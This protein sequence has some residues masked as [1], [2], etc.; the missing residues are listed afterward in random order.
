MDLPAW[1]GSLEIG[2]DWALWCGSVGESRLHSH[3]AAQAAWSSHGVGIVDAAGLQRQAPCVLVE[4]M[5]PHRLLAGESVTLIFVEPRRNGLVRLPPALQAS[6]CAALQGPYAIIPADPDAFFWPSPLV[7]CAEVDCEWEQ[8]VRD[9]V[10]ADLHKGRLE[11]AWVAGR[12]N[13]STD[14]FRHVFAERLGMPFKRFV[15]WRRLR[16]AVTLRQ[17]GADITRCAHSAGFADAAHFGRTLKA[18]FGIHASL[19]CAP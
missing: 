10:D 5:A 2:N 1:R 17:G 8:A 16:L 13:L 4:P 15:L 11:L 12:F 7:A 18:N 9:I 19:L 3:F 6:L 14:R